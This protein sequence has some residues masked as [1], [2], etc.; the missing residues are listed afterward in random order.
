MTPELFPAIAAFTRVAHHA[1]FTRA[2]AELGVSASAL[3]QTVR[4]LESRLG[5]RL[6]D[7]TTRR[8]S[9]TEIGRRFLGEAQAGLNALSAAVA[10]LDENLDRPAGL[11]K[12]NVSRSAADIVL[13][14]YL[15]EFTQAYPDIVVELNC[16][17]AFVD[18]LEG[19]FDAGIRIGELLAQDMIAAPLGGPQRLATFAA[20]AYLAQH[21]APARPEDLAGHRCLNVRIRPGGPLYRWE[22]MGKGG[23]FDIDIP[24]ALVSNDGPLLV[25][26]ARAGLGVGCSF[27]A[28][29]RGDFAAGTLVPLLQPWW[30]C[31]A[32]FH[33]YYA[34]RAHMP[35]KLRVFIEF[36]QT[37]IERDQRHADQQADNLHLARKS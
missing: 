5:V 29:V 19:G 27:E 35:R 24:G 31:F 37:R 21:A 10:G 11:L 13:M 16:D 1:S 32:G 33:L 15:A 22:Y 9:V 25:E 20:P 4:T 6:L 34:S 28:A 7:R 8:V 36:V 3:S 26:A 17:N 30:P 18:L 23:L 2:A 14:P 12:L